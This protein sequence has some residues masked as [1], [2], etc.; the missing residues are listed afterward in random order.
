MHKLP[1]VEAFGAFSFAMAF[2]TTLPRFVTLGWPVILPRLLAEG[3]RADDPARCR[4]AI[5]TSLSVAAIGGIAAAVSLN[6]LPQSVKESM[7]GNFTVLLVSLSIPVL[8]VRRVWFR[9][10]IGYGK[11]AV[12]LFLDNGFVA[13]ILAVVFVYA[14]R[15][16]LNDVYSWHLGLVLLSSVLMATMARQFTHSSRSFKPLIDKTWWS[17]A[18]ATTW[19]EGAALLLANISVFTLG[20]LKLE[21]QLGLFSAGSRICLALAI[22][23]T[24]VSTAYES[25]FAKS[26]ANSNLI[27]AKSA[28]KHSML[29]SS[30]IAVPV[31]VL[32]ATFPSPILYYSCGPEYVSA[33][34]ILQIL[35]VGQLVNALTG[36]VTSFLV[37]CKLEAVVQ[38]TAALVCIA[39]VFLSYF[40]II[41]HGA[42]GAAIVA[43]AGIAILNLWR[44]AAVIVFLQ[45]SSDATT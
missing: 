14:G 10:L 3:Q 19:A 1:G 26:M 16:S 23:P 25:G 27:E 31:F 7:G 44:L 8:A 22:F 34:A 45:E 4:G 18:I 33:A 35:A 36:P 21:E 5:L 13:S 32:I 28:F 17:A 6:L 41:Q 43:S 40:A 29:M 12:A 11:S 42:I 9:A 24:L 30:I 38:R 39:S 2:I 20:V 15:V 37:C